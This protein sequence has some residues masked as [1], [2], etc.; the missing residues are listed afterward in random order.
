MTSPLVATTNETEAY[1]RSLE[2]MHRCLS[3]SGFLASPT[4]IDNYARIWARDGIITGLAGLVSGDPILIEGLRQTLTT[5]ARYQGPHGEIPSNVSPD[6]SQVS[7]GHLAG[8]V[9]VPLWYVIGASAYILHTRD[10]SYQAFAWPGVERV[11]FLMGCWEYNNRGLIYTPISGN[12]A[13]EYI[14]QGY[15]LS[16]QLLYI[17][18]LHCAGLAFNDKTWQM[19]ARQLGQMVAFNYWP[20]AALLHDPLVYHPHAYHTQVTRPQEIMHW[21]PAFSPGGYATYFDGLA[22]ALILLANLSDA[23][24]FRK[25]EAYVSSLEQQT[26]S[27]LM[28]AFWPVIKP[29]DA[30]WPILQANHLYGQVKNQPYTYHNGGLWPV[31]TGLYV[32]G[33]Q[34]QGQA[35]RAVELLNALNQA[36]ARGSAGGHW[37]FSEYHHGLT[38]APMGTKYMAWSAAAGVLAYQAVRNYVSPLPL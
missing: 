19:K 36:N 31:L 30:N 2:V 13:D 1:R 14:Q 3:P 27:K 10:T 34:R 29:G 18:A 15:V 17:I 38:H 4:D 6:G 35:A 21:L 5:L 9:D 22:H 25:T 32:V 33:L 23:E 12:W 26:G 20:R 11:L 24:Q 37:E 7:Y 16:D 8:R 28:P